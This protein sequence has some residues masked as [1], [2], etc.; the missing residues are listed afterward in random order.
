LIFDFKFCR[1]GV[2]CRCTNPISGERFR[3]TS[4]GLPDNQ[5]TGSLPSN[6]NSLSF[7][8]LFDVSMNTVEGNL[9]FAAFA[10]LPYLQ[11]L[12][13]S[14]NEITGEVDSW[15]CSLP[16]FDLRNNGLCVYE[17]ECV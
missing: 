12:N 13:A 7:L 17:C 9:P 6:Y 4:L 3:V 16:D 2:T 14:N 11:V 15:I 8:T 10:N 5:L 1:S